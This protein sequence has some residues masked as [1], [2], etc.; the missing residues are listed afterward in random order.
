MTL[1]EFLLARIAEDEAAARAAE[2]LHWQWVGDQTDRE[3]SPD[4]M[5]D[6]YLYGVDQEN[7]SLRS[8]ETFPYR[9]LA[10]E[11][12]RFLI[13][14]DEV[15]TVAALHIARHDPARVLAECAAKRA[16]VAA[17]PS[18][19][20]AC[21]TCVDKMSHPRPSEWE[22]VRHP[23]PTLRTIANVYADHP[24]FDETWRTDG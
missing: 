6:E 7:V 16:I 21:E 2:G 24:D 22:P 23:C 13:S 17:H 1:T 18:V 20:G 19:S 5:L 8:V 11:G 9:S 4:P 3:V 14:T 15:R 10:G 12:P